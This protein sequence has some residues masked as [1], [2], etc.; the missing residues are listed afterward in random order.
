MPRAKRD[1]DLDQI[2]LLR[3]KIRSAVTADKEL[4]LTTDELAL[5][6]AALRGYQ[7][8]LEEIDA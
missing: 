1:I 6:Y 7:I 5:L 2:P 8:M 3:E 4:T